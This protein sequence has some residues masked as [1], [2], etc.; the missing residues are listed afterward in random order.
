MKRRHSSGHHAACLVLGALFVLLG[1][2]ACA[3]APVAGEKP[4]VAVW[5][6]EDVGLG[7]AGDSIGELL[8]AQVME[9]LKQKGSYTVV[10]RVRL[11]AVLEELRLGS[12]ELADEQARLRLGKIIGVKLMVFGGYQIFGGRMR[13]DLRLVEVESGKV[14]KATHKIASS[15]DLDAWL[16]AARTAGSEL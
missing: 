11:L 1:L 2:S 13:I 4:G 9:A 3:A 10:E 7:G 5:D 16:T 12:S 15:E 14:L 8:A 6:V